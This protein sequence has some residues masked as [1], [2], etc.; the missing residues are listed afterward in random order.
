M[1]NLNFFTNDKE[2][3]DNLLCLLSIAKSLFFFVAYGSTYN[4]KQIFISMKFKKTEGSKKNYVRER[5]VHSQ[6]FRGARTHC[7]SIA[8]GTYV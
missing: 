7:V 1:H 2:K 5:I 4:L 8:V 3:E 6:N